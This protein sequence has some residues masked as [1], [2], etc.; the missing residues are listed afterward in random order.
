M[1][2][3]KYPI[4]EVTEDEVRDKLHQGIVFF[5]YNKKDGTFREARG[6]TSFNII[7]EEFTPTTNATPQE[8]LIRYF[9][10]DKMAWRAFRM[11]NLLDFDYE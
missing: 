9:D 10:L 2:N 5:T 6:T 1:T 8:G 7:P 11:E 4:S 3:E